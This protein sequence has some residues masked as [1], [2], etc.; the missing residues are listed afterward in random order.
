VHIPAPLKPGNRTDEFRQF[1]VER[2]LRFLV[3]LDQDV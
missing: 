1:S 2:L 3:K